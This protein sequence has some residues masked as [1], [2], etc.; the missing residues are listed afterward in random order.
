MIMALEPKTP[1][2][3][4]ATEVSSTQ[5]PLPQNIEEAGSKAAFLATFTPQDD[6]AIMRKVDK[7]FLLLIGI[8]YMTK[9]VSQR[10][11]IRDTPSL[12]VRQID[13]LNASVVKV[14]QVG[15]DRNILAE[16]NMTSDEYNWVQSI[17]FVCRLSPQSFARCTNARSQIAYI[18]FEVPS[19]MLLKKMTPR[20]WQS[21][22]IISWGIVLA[23]HAAIRNRDTYYALRFLLGMMEAGL[24]PGLAAQL[25]SWYRS[26]EMGKPIMWM[27]GWQNCAGI[28]GSLIAYGIS[29]MNGLAGLSA[30]RWVYLLEGLATVLI[31]VAVFFVLPDYPKSPRTSAWL[32]PREQEYLEARLSENAPRTDEHSFSKDEVIT[33]LKDPRTYGFMFSQLLLN[34]GGYGLNWWLPTITTNLGFAGLPRN[35]LLNIPPAAAAVISII[36]VGLLLDRAYLTRPAFLQPILVGVVVCFILIFTITNKVG[37]YIACIFGNMFYSVYFI[38]FWACKF[39]SLHLSLFTLTNNR[40]LLHPRR[41]NRNSFHP[42]LPIQ[43]RPSRRRRRPAIVPVQVGV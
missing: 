41:H 4:D 29:H 27:F 39:S 31:G 13:Y 11:I 10:A 6:K 26:D 2:Q 22:I 32:S 38:P 8:L 19:N 7:R 16:L 20:L 9:N 17:Y 21:R 42:R 15:E 36:I 5:S 24:F 35:Q 18:I 12:I 33:S 37:I 23:C 28:F 25:C 43:R 1:V 40:A 14:L 3:D 30:W 34:L